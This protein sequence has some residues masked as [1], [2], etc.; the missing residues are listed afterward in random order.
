MLAF[1]VVLMDLKFSILL[2]GSFKA[3]IENYTKL[4]FDRFFSHLV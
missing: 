4:T 1:L 2:V 3:T